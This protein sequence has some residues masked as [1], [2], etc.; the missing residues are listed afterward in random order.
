MAAPS[1]P[2]GGPVGFAGGSFTG[3]AEALEL[4]RNHCDAYSGSITPTGGGSADTTALKFTSGNFYSVVKIQWTCESTSA[5]VDQYVDIKMNNTI[6]FRS[7]AEDDE[8]G[9]NIG[10]N[11]LELIIPAYTE[12]ELNVGLN[13]QTD[14]FTVL[15]AG[16]IYR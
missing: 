10:S 7:K 6:V 12:F 11:G 14:P 8:A 4:V 5:T 16:R 13:G 9:D 1:G 3:P 15:L 2:G